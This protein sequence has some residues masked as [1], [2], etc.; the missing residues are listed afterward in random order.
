[1]NWISELKQEDKIKRVEALL[2]STKKEGIED[3]IKHLRDVGFYEQYG[4][5]KYHG[6]YK[7]GLLDHSLNIL[8]LLNV[9]CKLFKI[10]FPIS[11]IIICAIGHDQCKE[12]AYINGRW[13]PKNSGNGHAKYSLEILKKYIVLTPEEETAIKYH[14]GMYGSFEFGQYGEFSLAELC[15]NYNSTKIA[16]LFYFCDDMVAQFFDKT[17]EELNKNNV[18]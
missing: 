16:K 14:M 8:N 13:N 15:D 11:S 5:I 7:G 6:N 1:M 3:Y 12:E 4:S 9:L 18:K 10:N 2:R 17:Q